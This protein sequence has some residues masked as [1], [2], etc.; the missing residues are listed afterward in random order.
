MKVKVSPNLKGSELYVRVKNQTFK[1]GRDIIMNDAEFCDSFT[2]SL[3]SKGWLIPLEK[4]DDSKI[5]LVALRSKKKNPM[6]FRIINRAVTPNELFYVTSEQFVDSQIQEALE[7]GFIIQE[8]VKFNEDR[9]L[10]TESVSGSVS[11]K[12][13]P[14]VDSTSDDAKEK[15]EKHKITKKH[16]DKSNKMQAYRP[17]GKDINEPPVFKKAEKDLS[18]I[19]L[20]NEDND[21]DFVDKD[22]FSKEDLGFVDEE[23]RMEK[24]AVSQKRKLIENNEEVE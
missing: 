13:I 3:V 11:N 5:K 23:Q 8:D 7:N 22:I 12:S 10:S 6:V 9:E 1:R 24:K 16:I 14:S 19:D 17:K 21:I 2:Q 20:G 18:F 4:F 15:T